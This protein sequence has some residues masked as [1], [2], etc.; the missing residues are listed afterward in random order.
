[1]GFM[2]VSRVVKIKS[3]GS[4]DFEDLDKISNYG[5]SISLADG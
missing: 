1:M 5:G 2:S 3:L 4:G